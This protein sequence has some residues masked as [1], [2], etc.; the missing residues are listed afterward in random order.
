MLIKP[1]MQCSVCSARDA[2]P[3]YY[4]E[5]DIDNID[6]KCNDSRQLVALCSVC[7]PVCGHCSAEPL[8]DRSLPLAE[9]PPCLLVGKVVL[10]QQCAFALACDDQCAG[11][12]AYQFEGS[13]HTLDGE[14]YCVR[15]LATRR[16]AVCFL[17]SCNA[18]FS[19]D[20][21]LADPPADRDGSWGM[22]PRCAEWFG[23][24][25]VLR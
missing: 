25:H 17:A 21:P 13:L 7:E 8:V 12:A 24:E 6:S 16:L 1:V 2:E 18:L 22:C 4:V 9:R 5:V 10:P 19:N 23:S 20:N 14:L 15:C 3:A 11:C